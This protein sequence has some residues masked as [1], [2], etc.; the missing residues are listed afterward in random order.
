VAVDTAVAADGVEIVEEE[1]AG[2]VVAVVAT[3]AVVA[4]RVGNV[5]RRFSKYKRPHLRRWPFSL[6]A[7]R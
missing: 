7:P 6:P 2:S 5:S 1:A 4:I 3:A